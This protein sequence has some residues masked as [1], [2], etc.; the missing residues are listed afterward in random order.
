M[1][2]ENPT[3]AAAAYEK[4]GNEPRKQVVCPDMN[5]RNSQP[6]PKRSGDMRENVKLGIE[7]LGLLV[8]IVYTIFS[9]LQWAQMRST[10]RLTKE[11][12]KGSD[13]A[14]QQ[15]LAKMQEQVNVAKEANQETRNLLSETQGA[16]F[17]ILVDYNQ[18]A[19]QNPYITVHALNAGKT[20]ALQFEGEATFIRLD[21]H[22]KPIQTLKKRFADD[23][24]L[25]GGSP[26]LMFTVDPSSTDAMAYRSERFSLITAVQYNNGFNKT[27][28]QRTCRE[29]VVTPG[30]GVGWIDCG[31]AKEWNRSINQIH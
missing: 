16:V 7:V 18:N 11:A 24:V 28:T 13:I 30:Q 29:M 5:T 8:L 15:T 20:P 1:Q 17:Q 31:N 23:S 26:A 22:G 6:E 4:S 2:A 19:G 21:R 27:R 3:N 12:L 25:I 10:N 9:A 14:L